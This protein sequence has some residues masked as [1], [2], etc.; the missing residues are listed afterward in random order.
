MSLTRKVAAF[1][2]IAAFYAWWYPTRWLGWGHWPRYSGFGHFARHLRF[3]DRSSRKLAR[4]IFHGMLMYQAKLQ[5]KQVF[6]FRIVD[7]ADELFVM[8]ATVSRARMMAEAGLPEAEKAAQVADLFCRDATR[9][10]K[11]L[12]RELWVNDDVGKYSVALGILKGDQAWMEQ[13]LEG[14]ACSSATENRTKFATG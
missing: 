8:T 2:R 10:V 5:N 7:I 1:S 11:K 4:Q 14:T 3:V 12:F 6:L 9:Q 13:L